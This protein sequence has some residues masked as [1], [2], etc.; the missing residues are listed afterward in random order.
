MEYQ[1][2]PRA[3][4]LIKR[5]ASHPNLFSFCISLAGVAYSHIREL[6]LQKYAVYAYHVCVTRESVFDS[7][8]QPRR[9]DLILDSD[10]YDRLEEISLRNGRS[11][12]D[13]IEELLNA[14]F[15]VAAHT[16]A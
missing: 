15:P 2:N 3:G 7:S 4:R 6:K 11:I 12:T 10:L 13:L 9:L 1:A 5:V 8:P 16:E 14:S